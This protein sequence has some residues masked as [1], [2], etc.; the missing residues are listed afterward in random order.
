MARRGYWGD[1]VNSPYLGFGIESEEESL[2]KQANGQ[3]VKVQYGEL[4][5]NPLLL[6]FERRRTGASKS[7]LRGEWE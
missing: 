1:I 7:R 5:P 2:F 3:H 6:S 4:A